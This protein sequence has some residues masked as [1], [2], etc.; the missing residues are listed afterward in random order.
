MEKH[1]IPDFTLINGIGAVVIAI[2]YIS[3]SSLMKEPN[4][5]RFNAILLG[6]AGAAYLSGGLGPAEFAYC[7]V[8][9]FVAYKGLTN[10]NWIGA[11]WLMHSSWDMVHHLYA[12]PIVPFSPSS[13][14]GCTVCDA[15]LAIWFFAKAPNVWYWFKKQKPAHA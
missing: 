2:I 5:Q 8:M 12:N 10:Y 14:A 3:L 11:G 9:T 15:V 1:I 7:T 4:R 6:G 13:S